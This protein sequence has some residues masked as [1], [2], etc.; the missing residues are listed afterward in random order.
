[1]M[2]AERDVA[3]R[4]GSLVNTPQGSVPANVNFNASGDDSQTIVYDSHSH[5]FREVP[6]SDSEGTPTSSTG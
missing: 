2:K 3:S 5:A 1:M 4:Q 6:L